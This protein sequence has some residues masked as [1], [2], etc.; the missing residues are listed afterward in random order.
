[1]YSTCTIIL[2]SI[3][4]VYKHD[5]K[6]LLY[7]W[8]TDGSTFES[9]KVLSKVC[10][11]L[12]EVF[13]K[14]LLLA[15]WNYTY[16]TLHYTTVF[17]ISSICGRLRLFSVCD[18]LVLNRRVALSHQINA[19]LIC[20]FLIPNSYERPSDAPLTSALPHA[21]PQLGLTWNFAQQSFANL[22][23]RCKNLRGGEKTE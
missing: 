11:I 3:A 17:W 19:K 9:T 2:S 10:M 12:P 14:V 5:T 6:V 20:D 16:S 7:E 22:D 21:P 13:T 23:H 15:I 1:M 18:L 4:L 8:S